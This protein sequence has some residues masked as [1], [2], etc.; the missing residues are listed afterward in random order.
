MSKI[1]QQNNL[2]LPKTSN[3]ETRKNKRPATSP[4]KGVVANDDD[5]DDEIPNR[6]KA[7]EKQLLDLTKRH[8]NLNIQ[9]NQLKQ[10][11]DESSNINGDMLN[12]LVTDKVNEQFPAL[13]N[14]PISQWT[15]KGKIWFKT[16]EKRND[17][18]MKNLNNIINNVISENESRKQMVILFGVP[19]AE[20]EENKKENDM[21]QI[22]TYLKQLVTTKIR[23]KILSD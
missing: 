21:K 8:E 6:I 16:D 3:E 11:V 14:A 7:L 9:F 17:N 18:S 10:Q 1:N 13:S 23:S 4:L 19:E 15:T 22:Q 2:D 20:Q 12:H 5:D